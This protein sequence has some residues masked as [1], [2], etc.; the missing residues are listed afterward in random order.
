MTTRNWE[1]SGNGHQAN[2]A[3]PPR[4]GHASREEAAETLY[5]IAAVVEA[6]RAELASLYARVRGGTAVEFEV[7]EALTATRKALVRMRKAVNALSQGEL[8]AETADT[9]DGVEGG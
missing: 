2:G 9:D 5:T 8:F 6:Q 3:P 1:K 7:G 4:F